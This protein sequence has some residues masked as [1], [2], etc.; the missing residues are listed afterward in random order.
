MITYTVVWG[1]IGAPL[2][3]GLPPCPEL[4]AWPPSLDLAGGLLI[5]TEMALDPMTAPSVATRALLASSS[6]ANS[7]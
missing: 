5:A 2:A 4:E 1:A 6:V 7:T 3:G